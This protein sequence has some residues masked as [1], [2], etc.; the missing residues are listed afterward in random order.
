MNC[1]QF[2]YF[3]FGNNGLASSLEANILLISIVWI[4]EPDVIDDTLR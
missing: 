3:I 4:S 1:Q 2:G